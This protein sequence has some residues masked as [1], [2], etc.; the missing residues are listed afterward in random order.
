MA[1]KKGS[2]RASYPP[3]FRANAVALVRSGRL[4]SAVADELGMSVETLRQ[5]CVQADRDE[6]RRDDGPTTVERAEIV[7][8][9][10]RVKVLEQEREIL[11]KAAAF[12]AQETNTIR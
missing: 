12:F 1:G 4:K 11:K 5:W 3:E 8:L 6:G 10:R 2:H 9:R 7:Q